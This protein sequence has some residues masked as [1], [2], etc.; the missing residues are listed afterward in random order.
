MSKAEPLRVIFDCNVF[1]QTAISPH[2]PAAACLEAA[3]TG[4]INLFI[5]EYVISEFRELCRRPTVRAKF[6]LEH[7]QIETFVRDIALNSRRLSEIPERYQHPVDPD[8]SPY[9]NLALAAEAWRLVSRD[10]HLLG[11]MDEQVPRPRLSPPIPGPANHPAPGLARGTGR[12]RR[13]VSR[14]TGRGCTPN[15]VTS[16]RLAVDLRSQPPRSCVTRRESMRY[17]AEV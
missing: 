1:F 2:G 10:K 17:G 4:K 8:D 16:T 12:G 7:E 13:A 11:L 3:R 9:V 6:N 15:R 5:S 14:R